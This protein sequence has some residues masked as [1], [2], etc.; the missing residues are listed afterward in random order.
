MPVGLT[1]TVSAAARA[2]QPTPAGLRE[3][4][5]SASTTVTPNAT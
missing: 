1:V 4:H 3:R 2:A 5:S